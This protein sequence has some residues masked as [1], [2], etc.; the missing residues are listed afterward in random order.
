M[1]NREQLIKQI[2]QA[3]EDHPLLLI[4]WIPVEE[5]LPEEEGVY[6]VLDKRRGSFDA[7]QNHADIDVFE[8]DPRIGW[9]QELNDCEVGNYWSHWAEIPELPTGRDD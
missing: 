8:V 1:T 2:R 5:R 4:E 7:G 9:C 6:F 3:P